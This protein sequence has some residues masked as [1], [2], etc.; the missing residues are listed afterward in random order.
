M[1][2]KRAFGAAAQENL[3]CDGQRMKKLLGAALVWLDHNH[4]HVNRLNVFPVP[5]GDTGTNMLLTMREAYRRIEALDDTNVS[6]MCAALAAGALNGARG[7]SGTILS[8]L[9]EGFARDSA[10]KPNSTRRTSPTPA[11]KRCG[12]R[13]RRSSRR[14][15]ARF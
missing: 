1:V 4:E 7:N 15:K 6:R 9:W 12:W 11:R 2:S 8:Q 10:A 3:V 5:D 14:R 13:M